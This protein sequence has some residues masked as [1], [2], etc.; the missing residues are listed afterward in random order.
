[1]QTMGQGSGADYENQACLRRRLLNIRTDLSS[2]GQNAHWT[3]GG[4]AVLSWGNND[5]RTGLRK[6]RQ[7]RRSLDYVVPVQSTLAAELVV[8]RDYG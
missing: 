2:H 1:M 6:C 8:R 7:P 4:I 5:E 3:L